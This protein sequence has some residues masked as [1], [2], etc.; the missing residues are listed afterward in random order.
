MN[1]HTAMIHQSVRELIAK[2]VLA[3]ESAMQPGHSAL[4]PKYVSNRCKLSTFT[5]HQVAAKVGV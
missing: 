3:L 2:P 1:S 5:S 4:H